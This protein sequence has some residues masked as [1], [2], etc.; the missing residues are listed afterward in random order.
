MPLKCKTKETR[1]AIGPKLGTVMKVDVSDSL[2]QWG[3]CLR[4][5]VRIDV[6]K[7]TSTRK[8]DYYRRRREQGVNFKYERL[9]NFCY[10]CG[11]LS[12]ALRDCKKGLNLNN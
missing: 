6:T 8:K 5:R 12:H 2:V 1:W 7:K 9:P 11:L 10:R 4:V 3:K